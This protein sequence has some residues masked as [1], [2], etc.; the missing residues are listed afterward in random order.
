MTCRITG[1]KSEST[2]KLAFSSFKIP[3]ITERDIGQNRM[4]L[5]KLWVEPKRMF[6][7]F[8]RFWLGFKRGHIV[9]G[10]LTKQGVRT[11]EA[12]VGQSVVW[13]FFDRLLIR[14]DAF[15]EVAAIRPVEA[16]SEIGVES[17]GIYLFGADL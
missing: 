14:F 4:G 11:G 13:I 6:S 3:V 8:P 10:D 12:R 2:L 15:A 7:G 16:A 17:F 1:A 9:V 5:S